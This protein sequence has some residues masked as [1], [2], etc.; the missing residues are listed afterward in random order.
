MSTDDAEL[1]F[2]EANISAIKGIGGVLATSFGPV[3]HD[4]F[5]GTRTSSQG[6]SS[7]DEVAH[8]D[9]VVTGDG[10]AILEALPMEHP[11]APV[12]ERV[13]G[14]EFPG[15]TET[16]GEQITD[17]VTS[18]VLLLAALLDEAESLLDR[19]VHPTTVRQGYTD[20]LSVATESLR[21]SCRQLDSFADVS[22]A[23]HAVAR[24]SMTGNDVGGM[25]DQWA[26]FAVEA[27][28]AIGYPT[29]ETF[30]VEG[31]STGSVRE[32]KLLRGTVLPRNEIA[33]ERMPTAVDDATVLVLTGY[34]R[35][36]AGDGRVGGLQDP[37]L[38]EDATIRIDDPRDITAYEEMYA[39]RRN[40]IVESLIKHDV[41]VVVTRLGINDQY[42][43]QLADAD[44]LAI[45]GV[46]RLKLKRV[47]G[48][49]GASLVRDPSDITPD[50]LGYAGRVEQQQAGKRS[51]RR[52]RR[53]IVV[54]D[55]CRNP[56]SMTV[57]LHGNGGQLR[58]EATRQLR[59][60]TAA[61]ASARGEHGRP[62]G[63]VPGGG[64]VDI[65]VAR[66][67]RAAASS[68]SS[69]TQLAMNAFADAIERLPYGLAKNAGMDPLETIA[70]LRAA[71][72]KTGYDTGLLLPDADVTDVVEHGV[73][74]PFAVK[75][76]SYATAVEVAG[77]VLRIDD[78][79]D[80]ETSREPSDEGDAIFD[81]HAEKHQ[82]HL[83]EHGTEDTIWE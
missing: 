19:G 38:Q 45:R 72:G 22:A 73:L 44:I 82:D 46:N 64:A 41:D 42:L 17:G 3:S 78:A 51:G 75:S 57:F 74:D 63:V 70:D 61:V 81:D 25:A 31:V 14:D 27:A 53:N 39:E 24:T 10:R 29:P 21:D 35:G 2:P 34:Q 13:A 59:T 5:I 58:D 43:Q 67:V 11:I 15:E 55:G 37:E 69:R 68:E 49:T 54:F 79:I 20:A 9:Y 50:N 76:R 4:K 12:L 66:D 18:S 80:A 33:S 47:A 16:A 1:S 32:S 23:E 71:A 56:T 8:D 28:D 48:A 6:A 26:E 7:P 36:D 60:A 30:G 40:G 52:T 83:D 65:G 77:T 62:A